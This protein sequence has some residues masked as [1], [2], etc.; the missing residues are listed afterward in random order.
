MN[1]FYYRQMAATVMVLGVGKKLK[2]VDYPAF[3][4]EIFPKIWPLPLIFV[5]NQVFGLGGTKQL[6]YRFYTRII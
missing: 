5:G 6:R 4:K 3:S 1:V 2:I